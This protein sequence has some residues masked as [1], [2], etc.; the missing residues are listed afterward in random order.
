[1]S[2]TVSR[3]KKR[4]TRNN[5][6]VKWESLKESHLKPKSGLKDLFDGTD[7]EQTLCKTGEY[8]MDSPEEYARMKEDIQKAIENPIGSKVLETIKLAHEL[9]L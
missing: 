5:V 2:S 1:M 7:L 9:G 3:K 6:W 4:E 8:S